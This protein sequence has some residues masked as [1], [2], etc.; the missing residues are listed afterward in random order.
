MT[1]ITENLSFDD[2]VKCTI[3][4]KDL[5]NFNE[6]NKIYAT[7][8]RSTPPARETVEVSKLP[9]DVEIEISCIAVQ[10]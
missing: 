6:V 7:Y 3:F 1:S 9:M 10:D 2:I 8:F 5:D 4:L